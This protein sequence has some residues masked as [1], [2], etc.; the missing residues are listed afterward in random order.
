MR[1]LCE[2]LGTRGGAVRETEDS[3]SER[4]RQPC[5]G[6][7]VVT[8]GAAIL[9]QVVEDKQGADHIIESVARLDAADSV[10]AVRSRRPPYSS[11]SRTRLRAMR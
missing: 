11:S 3:R 10:A 5:S 1:P 4:V 2:M 6:S 7:D 9:P 8:R